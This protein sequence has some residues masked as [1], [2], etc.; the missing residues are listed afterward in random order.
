[1]ELQTA[2]LVSGI[3][4]WVA[5]MVFARLRLRWRQYRK[6][7]PSPVDATVI[8][9]WI[10]LLVRPDPDPD[11]ATEP[12]TA[13]ARGYRLRQISETTTVVDR[14]KPGDDLP[15]A[16]PT[17]GNTPNQLHVWIRRSFEEGARYRDV[18]RD[19]QTL[20]RVSAPTVKRA[21][22]RVRRA[23]R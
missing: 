13:R 20:F 23:T 1:M 17:N 5:F 11:P 10:K 9:N 21:I 18:V 2:Q 7:D 3:L 19:G 8:W 6:D 16:E 22:A 12:D 14:I 4:A 15:L